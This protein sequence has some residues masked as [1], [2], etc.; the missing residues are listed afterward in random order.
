MANDSSTQRTREL[1][2]FRRRARLHRLSV[3]G[4]YAK[5]VDD[6]MLQI[7]ETKRRIAVYR[8]DNE[9]I[10]GTKME[11]TVGVGS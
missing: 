1:A 11:S 5:T 4:K 9:V 10:V 6:L 8:N 2:W 7:E 3:N